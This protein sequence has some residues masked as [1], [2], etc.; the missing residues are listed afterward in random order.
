ML[1]FYFDTSALANHYQ[2]ELATAVVNDLFLG[3]RLGEL[4]V[5]SYLGAL[6]IEALTV[7]LVRGRFLTK[8]TYLQILGQF[9]RDTSTDLALYPLSTNIL[10]GL[11]EIIRN[12][13]LRAPDAIHLES[14]RHI[15]TASGMAVVFTASD[16]ALKDAAR[17]EGFDILDPED[18]G[19][20]QALNG[21]RLG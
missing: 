5:T 10:E 8:R 3:K 4:L 21:F 13:A 6:E 18:T 19:S 16:H 7:R 20:L 9:A 11:L 14:A 17:A 2:T 15:R 1:A 12:H